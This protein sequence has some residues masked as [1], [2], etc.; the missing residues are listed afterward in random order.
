M[1]SL[2]KPKQSFWGQQLD[3]NR[4]FTEWEASALA[5]KNMHLRCKGSSKLVILPFRRRED[6]PLPL[7]EAQIHVPEL[8]QDI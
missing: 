2:K 8:N 4:P 1:I 5:R 7:S 6:S 3:L